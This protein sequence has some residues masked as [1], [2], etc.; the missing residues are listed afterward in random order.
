MVASHSGVGYPAKNKTYDFGCPELVDRRSGGSCE[1]VW[2]WSAAL[3]I[4]ALFSV[5]IVVPATL[6]S[7]YSV[8]TVDERFLQR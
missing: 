7:E 2:R 1:G 4:P 6:C 8:A 3:W 5:E